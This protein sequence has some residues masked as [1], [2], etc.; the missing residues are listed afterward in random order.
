MPMQWHYRVVIVNDVCWIVLS[1]RVSG[2]HGLVDRLCH[3]IVSWISGL[4]NNPTFDLENVFVTPIEFLYP[5]FFSQD[6][7]KNRLFI[8][9]M[10]IHKYMNFQTC[11]YFASQIKSLSPDISPLKAFGT[12]GEKALYQGF[13]TVFPEATHL[14]CFNHFMTNIEEKLINLNFDQHF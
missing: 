6:R 10:L 1:A 4:C 5:M 11:H 2:E 7:G 12:D 8:G 14:R 3:M 13:S 9:P